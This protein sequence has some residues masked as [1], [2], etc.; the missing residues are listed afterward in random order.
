MSAVDV[1]RAVVKEIYLFSLSLCLS[2]SRYRSI[3]SVDHGLYENMDRCIRSGQEKSTDKEQLSIG[4][5]T[6]SLKRSLSIERG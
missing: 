4:V 3:L 1:A 2:R 5:A 6:S